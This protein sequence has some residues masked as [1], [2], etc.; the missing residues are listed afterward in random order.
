MILHI[1]IVMVSP[2]SQPSTISFS[3]HHH[4]KPSSHSYSIEVFKNH[5]ANKRQL[6]PLNG[7]REDMRCCISG[8]LVKVSPVSKK[9]EDQLYQIFLIDETTSVPIRISVYLQSDDTNPYF[10]VFIFVIPIISSIMVPVSSYPISLS[11]VIKVFLVESSY[12]STL[13]YSLI[14]HKLKKY[15]LSLHIL[16]VLL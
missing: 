6:I 3:I 7:L 16:L 10:Q 13:E 1:A 4:S 11:P 8:V 12:Q 2:I 9:S 14:I 5:I 15:Q